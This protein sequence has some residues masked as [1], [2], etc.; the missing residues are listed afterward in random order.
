MK[1][2]LSHLE[3]PRVDPTEAPAGY[4]AIPKAVAKVGDE[5]ICRQCDWRGPCNDPTTDLLAPGHRCMAVPVVALRDGKTYQ[6]NDGV[7]VVFK[8]KETQ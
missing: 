3:E 6:R 8:K 1:S 7:G 5:N 4:Y 2:L